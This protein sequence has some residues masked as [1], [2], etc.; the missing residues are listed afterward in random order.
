MFDLT[1]YAFHLSIHSQYQLAAV[2]THLSLLGEDAGD[3]ITFPCV[4]S[5]WIRFDNRDVEVV[6]GSAASFP[7]T[8]VQLKLHAT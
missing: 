7:E 3:H 8:E 6:T 2:M 4:F 5:E 1:R